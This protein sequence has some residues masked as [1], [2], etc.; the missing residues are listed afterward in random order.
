MSPHSPLQVLLALLQLIMHLQS[1]T[2]FSEC[3]VCFGSVLFL[4]SHINFSV[5]D[6]L[7][8]EEFQDTKE[9]IYCFSMSVE[10][11]RLVDSSVD[12][13]CKVHGCLLVYLVHFKKQVTKEG[14]PERQQDYSFYTL[15][16]HSFGPSF[17]CLNSVMTFELL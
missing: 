4:N 13:I 3:S 11:D 14:T 9:G 10:N 5:S 7:D 15:S 16:Y 8:L 6:S 1:C 2:F 12:D 17:V